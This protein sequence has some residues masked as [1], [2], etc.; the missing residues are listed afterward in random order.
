MAAAGSQPEGLD[1]RAIARR[2]AQRVLAERALRE[3]D[4]KPASEAAL[5]G[6][7]VAVD[8]PAAFAPS[9][10]RGRGRELVDA[11]SLRSIAD[12]A[13][14]PLQRGAI[15]T[16]L[17]R[18][19]ARRRRITFIEGAGALPSTR[20][21]RRVAI[22]SDHGGFALKREILGWLGQFEAVGVDLGTRDENPCDY[23][24]FA[25]AV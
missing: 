4:G 23:P 11:S 15:V 20:G 8:P 14:F 19:E 9:A 18:E 25:R 24:D 21:T 7:H 12:G 17:A 16:D 3:Q 6:V 5:L 13:Q 10:K 2:A 22:G 1:V